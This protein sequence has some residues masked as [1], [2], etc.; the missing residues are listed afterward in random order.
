M[1]AR[2]DF[3]K[4]DAP[5]AAFFNHVMQTL[6]PM[7]MLCCPDSFVVDEKIE[8]FND[9]KY[10]DT[11]RYEIWMHNVVTRLEAWH[12]TLTEYFDEYN[13]SWKYYAASKRLEGIREYGGDEKDYN[14]DGT[15]RTEGLKD[16]ELESYSV[17]SD[18]CHDDFK[19]I[20]QDTTMEHIKFLCADVISCSQLDIVKGLK[21]HFGAENVRTYR[22]DEDGNIHPLS[23]SE[24]AIGRVREQVTA[25]DNSKR[26]LAIVSGI[27]GLNIIFGEC[28]YNE[29]NTEAL[30][31]ALK[32][33]DI[34][35]DM[36]FR[37]L[38]KYMTKLTKYAPQ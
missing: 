35:Y 19:D 4:G 30:S 1:Y 11:I 12:S 24:Y 31:L 37:K 6:A 34:L 13:G 22:A 23:N 25:E 27:Q 9:R 29:D 28:K 21:E 8:P 32:A 36:D 18:L 5:I 16:E 33:A 14:A 10:C 20:V 17:I 7:R 15:V 26:L 2:F 3:I 38:E